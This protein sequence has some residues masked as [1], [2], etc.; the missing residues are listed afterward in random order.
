[1]SIWQVTSQNPSCSVVGFAFYQM[2]C[3]S[4]SVSF[5]VTTGWVC[6]MPVSLCERVRNV[7]SIALGESSFWIYETHGNLDI[8]YLKL[9]CVEKFEQPV[10]YIYNLSCAFLTIWAFLPSYIFI[11]SGYPEGSK[12]RFLQN[13]LTIEMWVYSPYGFYPLRWSSLR[14]FWSSREISCNIYILVL[15]LTYW[16]L[17][18]RH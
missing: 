14:K 5:P 2:A 11:Y 15:T 4:S 17:G 13:H 6:I 18:R 10:L 8:T 9:N 1:M 7:S 12:M 16:I 3:I